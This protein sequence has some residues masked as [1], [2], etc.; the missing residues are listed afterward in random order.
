MRDQTMKHH[1]NGALYWSASTLLL[2]ALA[3]GGGTF[4]A[5]QGDVVAQFVAIGCFAIAIWSLIEA[6]QHESP[7]SARAILYIVIVVGV[8]LALALFQL[9]PLPAHWRVAMAGP[10]LR[11]LIE[12]AHNL[13]GVTQ[14]TSVSLTPHA[15]GATLIASL[16]AVAMWCAVVQLDGHQRRSLTRLLIVFGLVAAG[17][18]FFQVAQGPGSPFRFYSFTN[19]SEA[20]GFFANRNHHAAQLAVTLM[21]AGAVLLSSIRRAL[22]HGSLDSTTGLAALVSALAI[23]T[24]VAGLALARS[25]AGI[26]MAMLALV[27]LAGLALRE[28]VESRRADGERKQGSARW[29]VRSVIAVLVFASFFALQFGL[30]R[31]MTRFE[32]DPLADLRIPLSRT[33]FDAAMANLPLGTGLGS[34]VPVYAT[35]ERSD[36]IVPGFANRAH[37]DLAEWILETGLFGAALLALVLIWLGLHTWRSWRT[38]SHR[39]VETVRIM[40]AASVVVVL[41]LLH[42]LADYPLRT[43]ALSVTFA[44]CCGLLTEPRRMPLRTAIADHPHDRPERPTMSAMKPPSPPQ[45]W[46]NDQPWPDAWQKTTP[47]TRS[48]AGSHIEPGSTDA[49]ARSGG[50]GPRHKTGTIEEG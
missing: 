40:R 43:T 36:D 39:D 7:A 46:T 2:C 23:V 8:T 3:L 34:F 28:A 15:T 12:Q 17:L 48:P 16:P 45:P 42:S 32:A 26:L 20:V 1:D 41:L 38:T 18:G 35:L 13:A 11:S 10:T 27:A 4:A 37:N 25:R 47:S 30:H 31:I 33:T 49:D 24:I 21:F 19:P 44:L 9:L 14:T 6:H 22:A 29:L 50:S 5:F